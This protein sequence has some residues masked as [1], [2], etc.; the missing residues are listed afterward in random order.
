MTEPPIQ[1]AGELSP[2]LNNPYTPGRIDPVQLEGAALE[3][4]P[5]KYWTVLAV[6]FPTIL[7]VCYFVPGIGIPA[8]IALVSAII[9]VPLMRGRPRT[10]NAPVLPRPLSL[11]FSSWI[12]CLLFQIAATAVFCVICMPLGFLAVSINEGV[13]MSLPIVF[14][15]SGVIAIVAYAFLVRL[16]LKMST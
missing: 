2:E 12:F 10:L 15:L 8:L 6:A 11:L 3:K 1:P 16:S 5:V 14:G 4:L 9:R 7:A 13:G